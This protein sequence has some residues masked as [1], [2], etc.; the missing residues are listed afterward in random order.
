MRRRT[1][2]SASALA[3]LALLAAALS[4]AGCTDLLNARS[5]EAEKAGRSG[6]LRLRAMPPG[7]EVAAVPMYR[8]RIVRMLHRGR[9]DAAEDDLWQVLKATS[10]PHA[11]RSLWSANDLR[12]AE[13]ESPAVDVLQELLAASSDRE[14]KVHTVYVRENQDFRVTFGPR[15]ETVDILWTDEAGRL[16]GRHFE[17]AQVEFRVVCRRRSDDE[18]LTVSVAIVPEVL[19]G[20][21]RLRWVRTATGYTRQ[22]GRSRF[23]LTDLA[24]EVPLENERLL[25]L[26]GDRSSEVSLGGA[27]FHERRGPDVWVQTAVFTVVPVSPAEVPVPGEAELQAGAE[28]GEEPADRADGSER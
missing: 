7:P 3:G 5:G 26:G 24:V 8:V 23:A 19:Y 14:V 1:K 4:S 9:P 15:R 17:D 2:Q 16:H 25:V 22:A 6:G 28:A 21:E 11:K 12:L 20:R 10:V 27:Y 18:P 13:G